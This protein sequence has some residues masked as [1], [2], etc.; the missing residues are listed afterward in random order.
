MDL[1]WLKVRAGSVLERIGIIIWHRE[2]MLR[3]YRLWIRKDQDHP[4]LNYDHRA[5]R[6]M[7]EKQLR[8]YFSGL[9]QRVKSARERSQKSDF[10]EAQ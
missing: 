9:S 2:I 6:Y 3:W 7:S 8:V 1:D 10:A 4:S 5:T